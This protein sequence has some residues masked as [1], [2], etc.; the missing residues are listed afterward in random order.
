[1]ETINRK[2]YQIKSRAKSA[3]I[4]I[5]E[6][7]GEGWLGGISAKQFV[8]DLNDLGSIDKINVRINSDGGSVFDGLTHTTP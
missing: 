6:D 1:M 8:S 7:I 2:G 5:Y 3:E 4:L